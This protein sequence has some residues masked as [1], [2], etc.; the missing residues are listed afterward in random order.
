MPDGANKGGEKPKRKLG[1]PR[2]HPDGGRR[3]QLAFRLRGDTYDKL[4]AIAERRGYS[5]SEV[6]EDLVGQQLKLQDE[7]GTPADNVGE[8]VKSALRVAAIS[9]G[10]NFNESAKGYDAAMA[11]ALSVLALMKRPEGYTE[12]S[13]RLGLGA[14]GAGLASLGADP[15]PPPA[16][17]DRTKEWERAQRIGHAAAG[18]AINVRRGRDED[19]G[20]YEVLLS[21]GRWDEPDFDKAALLEFLKEEA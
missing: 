7:K 13:P 6:V 18:F 14:L 8:M 3:P 9:A 21:R 5:L 2:L 10:A 16:E 4:K 1:R 17:D 11:A 12:P 20:F 19:H 15:S